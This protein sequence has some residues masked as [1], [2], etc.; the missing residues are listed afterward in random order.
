VTSTTET[1]E[2]ETQEIYLPLKDAAQ[3]PLGL[4]DT[5]PDALYVESTS[6]QSREVTSPR[7]RFAEIEE[8]TLQPLTAP[9]SYTAVTRKEPAP[10]GDG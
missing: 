3:R 10:T 1:R 5:I 9:C 6:D 7:L 8:L 2:F 4:M